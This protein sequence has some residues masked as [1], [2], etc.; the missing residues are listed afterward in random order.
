MSESGL[1][2]RTERPLAPGEMVRLRLSFPGLLEPFEVEGTVRWARPETPGLPA[3]VGV[4]VSEPG[5][6]RIAAL[7][8]PPPRP[9]PRDRPFRILLVED[10]PHVAGL[11]RFALRRLKPLA[12]DLEDVRDGHE[13]LRA[14]AR[15]R[16]DLVLADLR[17]PVLD[18]VELLRRL[19]AA[20]ETQALPVVV[21]SAADREMRL[22][23][24]EAG[25]DAVLRKPVRSGDVVETVRGLLALRR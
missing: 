4:E 13:A 10:N 6:R 5:R 7:V 3:G 1:F 9:P 16:P 11:Y 23:A 24:E 8:Q 22:A 25:A 12:V 18:G 15:Q 19:R 2:V 17:M 21:I 20:P 14:I